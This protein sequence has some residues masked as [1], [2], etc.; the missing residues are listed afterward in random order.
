MAPV[1]ST[2]QALPS[3]LTPQFGT[4][5]APVAQHDDGHLRRRRRR[6]GL[7]QLHYRIHPGPETFGP[8]DAP[9]PAPYWI[10]GHGNGAPSVEHA[11]DDGGGVVPIQRRVNRQ[12]QAVATP[13]GQH[14]FQQ[15]READAHVQFRPAGAGPVA[16]V[17][18][19][20]PK[21]LP[22]VVPTAP[23]REGGGHGVL[24][25]AARPD[26]SANPQRQGRGGAGSGGRDRR[27]HT[28]TTPGRSTVAGR[29]EVR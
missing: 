14:P 1:S 24:A 26:G 27:F 7:Q 15:R 18:E 25:G 8:Q 22:P 3:D 21:V 4:G 17:V 11:D 13:S 29:G 12:S 9:E 6:Q 28:P 2:G 23:R 16:P 19:P 5:Q 10:R 20:L